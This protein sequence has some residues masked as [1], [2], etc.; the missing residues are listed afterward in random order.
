MSIFNEVVKITAIAAP[1]VLMAELKNP[2]EGKGSARKAEVV[3][4]IDALIDQPEGI[5]FPSWLPEVAHKPLVS[6]CLELT[7]FLFDKA[8]G[9]E[10]LKK[11]G[12]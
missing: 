7:V 12:L 11:L 1:L 6:G 8:G 5:D 3:A 2:E 9:P 10:L 4:A